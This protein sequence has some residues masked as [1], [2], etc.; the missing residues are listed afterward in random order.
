MWLL[1]YRYF[2]IM[3]LV[4]GVIGFTG[5][6]TWASS[7]DSEHSGTSHSHG[8][9]ESSSPALA[10]DFYV[11]LKDDHAN[12]DTLTVPVGKTVQFNTKDG[13]KHN[14]SVGEGGEEHEH[15]GSFHS[16]DFGKDEA[17]RATFKE[18]GTY[19]FHDHYNPNINVLIVAYRPSVE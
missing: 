10:T 3:V 7:R 1:K 15:T 9:S 6:F 2:M 12:P 19:S 16:G 18:P 8:D 4:F 13:R 14:I 17:W 5:A 11:D